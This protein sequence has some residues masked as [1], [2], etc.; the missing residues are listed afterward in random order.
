MKKITLL[1]CAI[2]LSVAAQSQTLLTQSIDPDTVD[3]SGVACWDNQGGTYSQNS[4]FRAYD[5]EDFGVTGDFEITELQYGQGAADDGKEVF[6][7]V[8]TSNKTD[9]NTATLTLVGGT[10]HTSSAADDLTMVTVPFS[11]TIPAGSIVVF[12]VNAGDSNGEPGQTYFPGTNGAGENDLSYLMAED[13]G[14]FEPTPVGQVAGV[15]YYVMNVL[16]DEVLSVGSN[17][18][19]VISVYPSPA[20]DILNIQL[21]SSVDVESA[22]L[23]SVLGKTT[24][25][26][27]SNGQMNVSGLA[28]GV[29][30]LSIETNLGAYTQKVV[31][32]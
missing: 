2:M 29:Y 19:D 11:A 10:G 30:F 3:D 17:L 14:I 12:E 13:C 7:N 8:Y 15:E 26:A 1:V 4:F 31:K 5:M 20:T 32:Q 23:T 22:S 28:P 18:A 27:Y 21:P 25:V 6:L 16:G 9:L 24:G